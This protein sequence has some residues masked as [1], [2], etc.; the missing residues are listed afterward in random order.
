MAGRIFINYRRGDDPGFT[1]RLFDRLE[2]SFPPEQLFID[3]DSIGAGEDFVR[4]LEDQVNQCDVLLAVIGRGWIDARDPAG[5]RRLDLEEDFVRIEIESGLKLGK[6]VIPVLVNNA[7]MPKPDAL[8]EQLKPLT[9]RNAV[10]LTHDRFKADTQGLIKVLES[11][12]EEAETQRTARTEAE[13]SAAETAAR[14]RAED[15]AERAAEAE[16][17]AAVLAEQRTTPGMGSDDLRKFEELSNWNFI[18]KRGQVEEL[19][20]HLARFPGG[21]TELYART[22][23]DALVWSSLGPAPGM[24]QL[25]GYLAEFPNG[26]KIEAAKRQRDALQAAADAIRDAE[27]RQRKEIDAWA[28]A[29]SVDTV[30]AY[31]EFLNA[32]PTSKNVVAAR[33][34]KKKLL[35]PEKKSTYSPMAILTVLFVAGLIVTF[36]ASLNNETRRTVPY[37]PNADVSENVDPLV[38]CETLKLEEYCTSYSYCHWNGHRCGSSGASDRRSQARSATDPVSNVEPS[39]T[40]P[41]SQDSPTYCSYA[42]SR[43]AC[44]IYATCRWDGVRCQITQVTAKPK[45]T[46]RPAAKTYVCDKLK[47]RLACEK[48]ADCY[49]NNKVCR[50]R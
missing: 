7:E 49:W 37:Q 8:P 9:R 34:R 3:V 35:Q 36:I 42:N 46:S 26:A 6:R 15:E 13:R 33:V 28:Q 43:E 48:N 20:N 24:D 22:A 10:R 18:E 19:R 4:V 29:S 44:A 30:A 41:A 31:D 39:D 5:R 47:K 11:A 27:E 40:Q 45:D 12:L 50:A 1:G 16:R 25:N 38:L 17:Q 32:W 14:K 23:L 21:I 2:Q